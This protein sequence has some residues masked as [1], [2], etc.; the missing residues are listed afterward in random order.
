MLKLDLVLP[1]G[2]GA[3]VPRLSSR[4][5]PNVRAT[6]LVLICGLREMCA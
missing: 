3:S 1:V 2:V 5:L 4:P 6:H